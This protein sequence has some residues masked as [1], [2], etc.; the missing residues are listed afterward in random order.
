M[1]TELQRRGVACPAP[2][3]S[4]A[5]LRDA[6]DLVRQ[7]HLD[8]LKAGADLLTANTFRT[9]PRTLEACG[10]LADGASLTCLAVELARQAARDAGSDALIAASVAPAAD[11]YRPDLVPDDDALRREHGQLASWLA[12]AGADVAWIETMNTAREARIAAESARDA[13][14]AFAVSFVLRDDGRLLGGDALED[15]VEGVL[16][17]EPLCL[18]L[19]CM[20]PSEILRHLP[21]LRGLTTGPIVAYGHINNATATPGWKLA[22]AMSPV[23]YATVATHWIGQGA[24]L[25]GG[26]CGTSPEHVA[27]LSNALEGRPATA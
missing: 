20:P 21:R 7:I 9:N 16:P 17:L 8:Y 11:C 27:A 22:Q 19:N 24:T 1:G 3:W 25:V 4:A 18:G 26:C 10:R 23:A 13:G 6:P 5:A 15:A 14:L 12:A 2:L